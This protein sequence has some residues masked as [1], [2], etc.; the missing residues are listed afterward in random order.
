MALWVDIQL[1]DGFLIKIKIMH[2]QYGHIEEGFKKNEEDT[3]FN[4]ECLGDT[5]V[6]TKYNGIH[7]ERDLTGVDFVTIIGDNTAFSNWA[8]RG[9]IPSGIT[10][11]KN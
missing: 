1:L 8:G 2:V 5:E 6:L 9:M 10:Q 7:T 4:F 3:Y 11:D